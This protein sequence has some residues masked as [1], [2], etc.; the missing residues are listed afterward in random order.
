VLHGD[1]A[2]APVGAGIAAPGTRRYRARGVLPV[3]MDRAL[4]FEVRPGHRAGGQHGG[5]Q[6]PWPLPPP[7]AR[8]A[9]STPPCVTK[10]RSFGVAASRSAT[11]RWRSMP[12]SMSTKLSLGVIT[13]PR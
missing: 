1:A 7:P 8:R 6:Q 3:E 5:A 13:A 2:Q 12:R 9:H 4:A 10:V 11:A